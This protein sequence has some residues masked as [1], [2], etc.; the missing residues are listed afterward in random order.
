[1]AKIQYNF[2]SEVTVCVII[3]LTL[4]LVFHFLWFDYTVQ[5]LLIVINN[6]S[7]HNTVITHWNP[8][9][10]IT[11]CSDYTVQWLLIVLISQSL[12]S[13][14]ITHCNHHQ[15]SDAQLTVWAK[16]CIISVGLLWQE[17]YRKISVERKGEVNFFTSEMIKSCMKKV[18]A[19]NLHQTV[20]V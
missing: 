11:Q 6:Q 18:V 14:I 4:I 10:V 19:V 13:A 15:F 3:L 20:Q 17:D 5:W 7:L 1:M 9:S 2:V 16:E 12:H 8:Q